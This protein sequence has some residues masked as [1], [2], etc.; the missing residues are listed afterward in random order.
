VSSHPHVPSASCPPYKY[1]PP[2]SCDWRLF[3]QFAKFQ[4]SRLF[5]RYT[6][7]HKVKGIRSNLSYLCAVTAI[8]PYTWE[9]KTHLCASTEL[10]H[11]HHSRSVLMLIVYTNTNYNDSQK[12]DF[13]LYHYIYKHTADILQL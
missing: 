13:S 6:F 12:Q 8:S 9:D 5:I 11:E 1:P 4:T 3:E 10:C 2:Y 7:N